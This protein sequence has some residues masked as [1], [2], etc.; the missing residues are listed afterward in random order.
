MGTVIRKGAAAEKILSDAVL[1]MGRC[2]KLGGE[3]VK[4][5][6]LFLS[7]VVKLAVQSDAEGKIRATEYTDAVTARGIALVAAHDAVAK[8]FD[9]LSNELG[10]PAHDLWLSILFPGG[11]DCTDGPMETRPAQMES[12]VTTLE[13]VGHPRI[14]KARTTALA[15]DIRTRVAS[16]RD[17][18]LLVDAANGRKIAHTRV[19]RALADIGQAQLVAFKRAMLALHY[20]ETEIA[21]V[22]PDRGSRKAKPEVPP[23]ITP[24]EAT[25]A[26]PTDEPAEE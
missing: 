19:A 4:Q 22:I 13:T 8:G 21:T 26:P 20:S 2:R 14:D 3:W 9:D 23:E 17:A 10:R 7:E 1:V 18:L 15:A 25:D 12:V 16:L 5:G 6:E 11:A 24:E